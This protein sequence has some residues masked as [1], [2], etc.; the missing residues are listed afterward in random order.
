MIACGGG[1]FA[2][3]TFAG[4]DRIAAFARGD[5]FFAGGAFFIEGRS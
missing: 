1:F 4:W 5:G 3:G 2:M